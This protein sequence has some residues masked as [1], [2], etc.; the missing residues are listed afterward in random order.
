MKPMLEKN[1]KASCKKKK[2]K[3]YMMARR[4]KERMTANF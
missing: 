2:K 4:R 1:P 3:K